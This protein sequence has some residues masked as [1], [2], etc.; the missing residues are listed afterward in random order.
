M[1]L[2]VLP[3]LGSGGAQRATVN[4]VNA[5]V[6]AGEQVRLVLLLDQPDAYRV[7]SRVE[8]TRL[9]EDRFRKTLL[10][11]ARFLR[12]GQFD[13]VYSA[14][15]HVN[16]LV[17][18]ALILA[19]KSPRRYLVSSLHNNPVLIRKTE[20]TPALV[21]LYYRRVLA[22]TRSAIC[23]DA[24]I[25]DAVQRRYGRHGER[26]VVA[27]NIA[28]TEELTGEIA[29][30]A[31]EGQ[32][33]G[34]FES[35]PYILWVGR[36][37]YQ[38]NVDLLVEI[39]QRT[40]YQFVIVGEGDEASKLDQI[41]PLDRVRV[42]PFQN[43]IWRFYLDASALIL[44]SRYE[45]QGL[46]LIEAM[47]CGCF[48]IASDC[49]YGPRSVIGDSG[50]GALVPQDSAVAFQGAIESAL[51]TL[52]DPRQA[53]PLQRKMRARAAQFSEGALVET[54]RQAIWR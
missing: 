25:K 42:F 10:P 28:L 52:A 1:I 21:D 40:D 18:L 41:R 20:G 17:T 37:C 12:R 24:G 32:P 15:W 36:F 9:K 7:D 29:D 27:S 14:M 34:L 2:V 31:R 5:L 50:A 45:G 53:E 16:F 38:K 23:V 39:V 6:R 22:L 48:P 47:A 3:S 44:T 43:R 30:E 26:L 46:V 33:A 8:I 11:L 19:G 51:K 35:G 13:R 4:L 49:E 54:Y